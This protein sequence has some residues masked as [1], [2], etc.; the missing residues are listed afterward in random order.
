MTAAAKRA[1]RLLS[2]LAVVA[3]TVGLAVAP[4]AAATATVT[5]SPGSSVQP[6][7]V[8]MAGSGDL[9]GGAYPF[10]AD[11]PK[12]FWVDGFVDSSQT[13]TW[14]VQSSAATTFHVDAL[15]KG[16]V[17]TAFDVKVNGTSALQFTKTDPD[18]V[19]MSAGTIA[20]PAGVSSVVMSRVTGSGGGGSASIK[21]I[22]L[23]SSASWAAYQQRVAAFRGAAAV[24]RDEFSQAGFGLM[25]QYGAWSYPATGPNPG[26]EDHTNAFDVEAFADLV[27]DTGAGYV[28]WSISWWTYQMQAPISAVDAAVGNG[29]R[30]SSR[31]LVGELAT[32]FRDRGIMFMLYYHTGH[33]SHLGY[34][35]T[36]FWRA[37]QWPDS[38]TTT[39]SGDRSTF[40][41]NWTSTVTEIGER[42]GNLLD[43]WFFDDAHVY[44][45]ADFEALGTAARA[46]NPARLLSWNK[47]WAPDYTEF[48]DVVFGEDGCLGGAPTGAA[49]DGGNGVL[50]AGSHAGELEHCQEMLEQDWGVYRADQPITTQKTALQLAGPVAA[51]MQRNAPVS[52]TLMMHYPG[53]PSPASMQVLSELAGLLGNGSPRINNTSGGFTYS[54]AGQWGTSSNRGAGD[55]SDDVAYATANGASFEYAFTGTGI[56]YIGPASGLTMA[57]VYLDGAKVQTI[58]RT[59]AGY[60]PQVV[61][62]HLTGLSNGSHTLKVVKTGGAYLQ[63]DAVAVE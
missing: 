23:V 53:V 49:P 38:F 44:Y 57:E 55:Y 14:S 36:D 5:L 54:L 48:E 1:T 8:L 39:A 10:L 45:P 9:A 33:D 11:P 24:T 56:D 27:Q 28:I 47:T 46:G 22:D 29:E 18:W 63:V 52:L 50:T 58:N 7:T 16:P 21:S 19:R 51:R 20:I 17:G 43:G 30:T 2:L 61:L 41:R 3:L 60:A 4:A 42:Y 34:N 6:P 59:D 40:F 35:S 37:Q 31:D 26:I 62:A 12:H 32:E 13:V 25:F 15:V